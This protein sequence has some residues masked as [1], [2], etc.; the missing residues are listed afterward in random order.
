MTWIQCRSNDATIWAIKQRIYDLFN[1]KW[2]LHAIKPKYYLRTLKI[3]HN[4]ISI[5]KVALRSA[6]MPESSTTSV[7]ESRTIFWSYLI[8]A[9]S[10]SFSV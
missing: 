3:H 5:Q 1:I 10:T 9:S 2:T 7:S 8:A 6:D 4:T